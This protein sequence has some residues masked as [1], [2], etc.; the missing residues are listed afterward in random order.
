M[1]TLLLKQWLS[2]ILMMQP[3]NTAPHVVTPTIKLFLS[4]LHDCNFTTVMNHSVNILSFWMA[5]VT[6]GKGSFDPHLPNTHTHKHTQRIVT[7]RLRN[8]L[9][10]DSEISAYLILMITTEQPFSSGGA[11]KKKFLTTMNIYQ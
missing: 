7:H 6:P 8:T 10:A 1:K 2:A 9:L 5:R 4:L 3:F 11:L